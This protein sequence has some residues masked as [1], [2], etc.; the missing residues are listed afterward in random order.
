MFSCELAEAKSLQ[1]RLHAQ[2]EGRRSL[3]IRASVEGHCQDVVQA[4][5]GGKTRL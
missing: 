4:L 1:D 3:C 5:L 2:I